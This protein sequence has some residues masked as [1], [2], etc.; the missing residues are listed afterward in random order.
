MQI[1]KCLSSVSWH[2]CCSYCLVKETY[3]PDHFLG[4]K[5]E[6]ASKRACLETRQLFI[7]EDLFGGQAFA[8]GP[9]HN[10][11]LLTQDMY[12][13]THNDPVWAAVMGSFDDPGS[14]SDSDREDH[15]DFDPTDYDG[16]YGPHSPDE[17]AL[18]SDRSD[19]E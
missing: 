13:H 8:K 1:S 19:C 14:D 7:R 18:V 6:S 12:D 10:A 16:H 3:A 15:H 5:V 4:E 11:M 2:G 17:A 9:G